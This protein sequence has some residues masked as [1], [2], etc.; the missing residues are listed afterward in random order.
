MKQ[1]R[2]AKSKTKRSGEPLVV[3]PLPVTDT[4]NDLKGELD[5]ILA[6]IDEALLGI[7]QDF[8]DKYI[9]RGGE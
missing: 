5:A 2:V 4:K 7:E 1:E 8:A 6:D 9:Q 3:E